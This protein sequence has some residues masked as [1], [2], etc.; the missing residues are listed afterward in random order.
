MT[1]LG[2]LGAVAAYLTTT[3]SEPDL[4]ALRI[5]LVVHAAGGL[6]VLFAATTLSVYKPWGKI[7]RAA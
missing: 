7:G 2:W 6:L 3:L 5:Q 4:G 1:D